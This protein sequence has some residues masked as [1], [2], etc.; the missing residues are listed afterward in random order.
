[1]SIWSNLPGTE[2]ETEIESVKGM[3]FKAKEN[4]STDRLFNVSTIVKCRSGETRS[5]S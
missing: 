5:A 1:M 3:I 4:H 2:F